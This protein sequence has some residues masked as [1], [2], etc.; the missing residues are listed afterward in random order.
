VLLRVVLLQRERAGHLAA[1]E[2]RRG[3]TISSSK[4]LSQSSRVIVESPPQ[5]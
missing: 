3:L 2:V 1:G 4:S 5:R